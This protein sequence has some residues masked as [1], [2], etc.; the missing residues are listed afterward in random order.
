M[1]EDTL[2]E[3]RG[4]AR[5]RRAYAMECAFEYFVALLVTD[6][7]L[8]RLLMALGFTDAQTGLISS[9]IT[10]AF[11]FQLL[12]VPVVQRITRVKRFAALFHFA[13]QLLFMGL[14]FVP[15]LPVAPAVRRGLAVICLLLAYVGN[16]LVTSIIYRWGNSF[17]HPRGRGL[18][19]A[20][21]EMLSQVLGM[22]VSLGAGWMIDRF[23]ADGR[24]DAGFLF[25]GVAILVFS[26]CDFVCLLLMKEEAG[27]RERE[28]AQPV[29]RVVRTLLG[30][31]SFLSVLL[32]N[33]LWNMALYATLG[34]LGTFK[35][36]ELAYT[37]G[38]VQVMNLLG[39]AGRFAFS[40]L[41]GRYSDRRSY[42][43]GVELA[44]LVAI[45]A[46]LFGMATGGP[47]RWFIIVHTLLYNI[48]LAGVKANLVNMT[49]SYV[50]QRYFVEASALKN[51]LSGLAGFLASLGGSRLL[52][53]I[54]ESGNRLWGIP[55]YGQ[56][57][58]ALISTLLLISALLFTHFV[59][60][61]QQIVGH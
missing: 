60:R 8:S 42:A 48:C 26:I 59:I 34:F 10:L 28:P 1:M 39:V 54:Q 19:T 18:F 53:H 27:C 43:A 13:G 51:S 14:Y 16:Y 40:R 5:S 61:R 32:L 58:L 41:F 37:V 6:S 22:A 44:L 46:F 7:F 23:A 24:T 29:F 45:A 33:V 20:N 56:Q 47:L 12:A 31:R 36:R 25:V 9:F 15:F 11:L 35:L 49:Y 4:H 50:D 38:Q 55:V 30:N 21:K 57:V 17:V 2:F 52:S 3:S